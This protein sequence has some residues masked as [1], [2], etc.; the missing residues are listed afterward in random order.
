MSPLARLFH[1]LISFYRRHISPRMAPRCR[2]YPSCSSYALQ[3]IE[4]HGALKG[5][6]LASW[7]LLR[8]NPFTQGGVDEVPDKG[9]WPG[10]PL[11]H[12]ELLKQW[13]NEDHGSGSRPGEGSQLNDQPRE[14]HDD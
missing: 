3:S 7:R 14:R 10:K 9:K 8:C 11:G 2:Y 6:L 13:E 5:T 1:A 12:A 4:V